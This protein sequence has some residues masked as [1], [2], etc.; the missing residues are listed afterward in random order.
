MCSVF[1]N[2]RL[3][4]QKTN[5]ELDTEKSAFVLLCI[6]TSIYAKNSVIMYK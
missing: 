6:N 3:G 5:S 1:L 2:F 4:E